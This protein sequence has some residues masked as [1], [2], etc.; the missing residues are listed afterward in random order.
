LTVSKPSSSAQN[1]LTDV[2]QR[3]VAA[4]RE[5]EEAADEASTRALTARA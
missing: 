2:E 3:I 5:R 4:A 1:A